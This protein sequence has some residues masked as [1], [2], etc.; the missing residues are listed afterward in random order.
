MIIKHFK[1]IKNRIIIIIIS[2]IT[3]FIICF[4][5]GLT[6]LKLTILLQNELSKYVFNYFIFT[7]ITE[8]FLIYFELSFFLTNFL[9]YFNILYNLICFLS[10]GLYTQEYGYLKIYYF[11]TFLLSIISIVFTHF[12][13]IPFLVNFFLSFQTISNTNDPINLYFEAKIY[14]YLKFYK[15]VYFNNFINFQ[16]LNLMIFGFYTTNSFVL[17]NI[18]TNRKYF[19]FVFLFISTILTP[20]DII[21]QLITYLFITCFFELS[22][23]LFI[24]KKFKV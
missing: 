13:M 3:F 17:S 5:Y 8:L 24:L 11:L 1:E 20:P 18:K 14:E 4:F 21:S 6:I 9:F 19:Y 23:F 16:L 12:L 10:S 22:L 7:S 15:E 2:Y